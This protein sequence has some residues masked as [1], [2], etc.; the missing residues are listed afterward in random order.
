[1]T[2]RGIVAVGDSWRPERG[3]LSD[4]AALA[5]TVAPAATIAP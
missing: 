1:V 5:V 2:G 3:S 4:H